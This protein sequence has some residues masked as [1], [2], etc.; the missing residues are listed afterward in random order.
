[1]DLKKIKLILI[2]VLAFVLAMLWSKYDSQFKTHTPSPIATSQH[3][4]T[5][6]QS[7][8]SLPGSHSTTPMTPKNHH[9]NNAHEPQISVKTDLLSLKIGLN[10]GQVTQL[11][12]MKYPKTLNSKEPIVLLNSKSNTFYQAQTG[13]LGFNAKDFTFKSEKTHYTLKGNK[14]LVIQLKGQNQQGLLWT[15][16]YTFYPNKYVFKIDNQ[17]LNQS[18]QTFKSRFYSQMS[19]LPI[20][21][22]HSLL[23]SYTAYNGTAISTPDKHFKKLSFSSLS[24]EPLNKMVQGGWIAMI[25]HYF[26]GAFVPMNH[27]ENQFY[28]EK[29][30]EGLINLGIA[31]TGFNLK[32]GKH[33]QYGVKTYVGPII[34]KRL[35]QVAPH[36][37]LAVDYGW[38]WFI[39]ELLFTVLSFIHSIV[40]NWGWSII[41]VTLI[42]KLIFYPLSAKSYRSMA[43]MKQ[44]Q[45]QMEQLKQQFSGDKQQLSKATMELYR[46]EKI[47]PLGGCLPI[48]IQIPVFIALYWVL[49]ESVELRQAPFIFWIHDLSVKDPYYILPILMGGSMVLQQFLSPSA[50]DKTQARV[51]MI[52]PVMFTILFLNF[53][54]GLVLYWIVN[55]CISV[56]QQ[57]YITQKVS[58]NKSKRSSKK[59]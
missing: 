14:P 13:F 59:K 43:K 35:E 53:P 32:P 34:A 37:N 6:N 17:L 1:M 31:S 51:M 2:A 49:I 44:L 11:S 54:S 16:T 46:K 12:L 23:S 39:S 21:T 57:W 48:L 9:Q 7:I 41:L 55:N 45:P 58:S 10:A 19:R 30:N 25:Q 38:L 20:A 3:S 28:S 4:Q 27:G 47:N 15:K 42:I 29:T 33:V 18:G 40:G 26:M 56:F 8:P 50:M 5:Q 24:S 22:H 52:M 36:L